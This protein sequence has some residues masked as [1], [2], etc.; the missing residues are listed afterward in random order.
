MKSGDKAEED[1]FGV[2][3][4]EPAPS[5][6]P[7]ILAG[8]CSQATRAQIRYYESKGGASYRIHPL[9][10]VEG[11]QTMDHIKR[12]LEENK[13]QAVLV[14]TSAPPEEVKQIRSEWKDSYPPL[15]RFNEEILA[16]TAAFALECGRQK[17]VAAGGETSGAIMQRLGMRTFSIG[18]SAAPGVPVMYPAGHNGVCRKNRRIHE[19]AARYHRG[20]KGPGANGVGGGIE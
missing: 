15:D 16:G 3:L 12:F 11:M 20:V 4:S 9:K 1:G 10:Y 7:I 5:S 19:N 6:P 2:I 8:S 18:K 17:I 14:Y 13:N